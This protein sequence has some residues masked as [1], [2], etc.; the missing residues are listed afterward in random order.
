MR[1]HFSFALVMV[2]ITML[3][4]ASCEKKTNSSNTSVPTTS[5]GAQKRLTGDEQI[6]KLN[7]LGEQILSNFKTQEQEDLIRLTD[8]LAA[9]FE[10]ANWQAVLD[11]AGV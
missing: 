2:L 10:T 1:Q 6:E 8:Y 4:F 3:G 9:R 11:S 5:Q 7:T